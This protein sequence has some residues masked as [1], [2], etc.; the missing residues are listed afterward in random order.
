M[1]VTIQINAFVQCFYVVLFDFKFLTKKIKVL[2][3]SV[4]S[5]RPVEVYHWYLKLQ[6][7]ATPMLLH[8]FASPTKSNFLAI[9]DA[10]I[11][12]C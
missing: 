6:Q 10:W 1:C 7:V 4:K 12:G 11:E 5:Y 2:V 8:L 3:R 9:C